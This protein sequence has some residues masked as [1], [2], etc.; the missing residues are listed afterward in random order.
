M[1]RTGRGYWI[2]PLF[3]PPG[4]PFLSARAVLPADRSPDRFRAQVHSS[5][6]ALLF[7]VPSLQIPPSP[8]RGRLP[9]RVSSLFATSPERVHSPRG[10]P[11]PRYVPSSGALSLSTSY[12]ALRLA[13][14]FHPAATFRALLVQG[15][16]SRRS[17]PSSSEGASPLA[18][19]HRLLIGRNRCP[20]P[21]SSTPRFFSASSSVQIV[22]QL[23][24]RPVAPLFEF[25][26]L[27]VSPARL[28]PRL[29][30]STPLVKLPTVPSLARWPR[31]TFFSVYRRTILVASSPT[32][33]TCPRISNLP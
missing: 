26:L 8:F 22:R 23:A 33:P 32:R 7:R 24:S 19:G 9:A 16:L 29:T 1:C 11:S 15:L 27:Q 4:D 30:Q 5:L 12:S 31:P 17:H 21:A 2:S 25:L 20:Q 6:L 3:Q 10:F 14:L 13:G 28:Q 18:V